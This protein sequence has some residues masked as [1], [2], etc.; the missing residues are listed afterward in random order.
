MAWVRLIYCIQKNVLMADD[1]MWLRKNKKNQKPLGP[2]QVTICFPPRLL[3]SQAHDPSFRDL[4]HSSFEAIRPP[5]VWPCPVL[6]LTK[7]LGKLHFQAAGL[8]CGSQLG[9]DRGV[10]YPWENSSILK[11]TVWSSDIPPSGL[12]PL[13]CAMAGFDIIRPKSPPSKR[14][15]SKFR[16]FGVRRCQRRRRWDGR[17]GWGWCVKGVVRSQATLITGI[18]RRGDDNHRLVIRKG[19]YNRA[20]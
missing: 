12:I 17:E 19:G 14:L 18:R 20:R 11:G 3:W 16:G 13:T 8:K 6:I 5:T 15:M 9:E 2:L 7:S 1:K 10:G 4:Q